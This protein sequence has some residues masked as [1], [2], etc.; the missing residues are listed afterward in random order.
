MF[1]RKGVLDLDGLEGSGADGWGA[2]QVI[3]SS[4]A[5]LQAV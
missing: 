5:G 2:A 3:A 4:M 1:A